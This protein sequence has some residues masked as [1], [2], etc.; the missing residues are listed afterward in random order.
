MKLF[1]VLDKAEVLQQIKVALLAVQQFIADDTDHVDAELR[2]DR[3]YGFGLRAHAKVTADK[4]RMKAGDMENVMLRFKLSG[5]DHDPVIATIDSSQVYYRAYEDHE[6]EWNSDKNLK[7]L[8]KEV[9]KVLNRRTIP[10]S[11]PYVRQG[12]LEALQGKYKAR[13]SKAPNFEGRKGVAIKALKSDKLLS[14]YVA[15][16]AD[17]PNEGNYGYLAF[18]DSDKP[19]NGDDVDLK[20]F[21]LESEM[22]EFVKQWVKENP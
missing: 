13:W 14:L 12:D 8:A 22:L 6:D 5:K 10:D 18:T 20:F 3:M 17:N 11:S 4:Y 19:L 9:V 1:E 7:T 21:A 15:K 2:H 16:K